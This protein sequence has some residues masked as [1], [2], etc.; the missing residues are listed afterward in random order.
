MG[1][2]VIN[3]TAEAYHDWGCGSLNSTGAC[4]CG[5]GW[6]VEAIEREATKQEKVT[7]ALEK[8]NRAK[9]VGLT[10]TES[11]EVLDRI[12]QEAKNQQ[13]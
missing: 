13:S 3:M 7:Q 2:R 9:G 8:Q 4:S 1:K 12:A 5:D 6:T 11:L 10:M